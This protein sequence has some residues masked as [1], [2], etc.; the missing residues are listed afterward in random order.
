[1]HRN[2]LKTAYGRQVVYRSS[3]H[4]MTSGN[5]PQGSSRGR[6]RAGAQKGTLHLDLVCPPKNPLV[7]GSPA[8]QRLAA[9]W[10]LKLP[11]I[12]RN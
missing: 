1:M 2:A 11:G 4:P 8:G 7:L 12:T 3:F 10:L 9:L 5:Y 6:T